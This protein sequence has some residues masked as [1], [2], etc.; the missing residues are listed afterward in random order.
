MHEYTILGWCGG[1]EFFFMEVHL[2]GPINFDVN[3]RMERNLE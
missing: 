2:F 3:S 1:I